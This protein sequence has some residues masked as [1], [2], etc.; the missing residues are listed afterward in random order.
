[1]GKHTLNQNLSWLNKNLGFWCARKI[2]STKSE[3]KQGVY[4][5]F[6]E[7]PCGCNAAGFYQA[8]SMTEFHP[9]ENHWHLLD[10]FDN[11]LSMFVQ[12]HLVNV[13]NTVN[14]RGQHE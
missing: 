10:G 4:W 2:S 9:C 13:F 12:E 7:W 5:V 1:M 6:Y 8:V 3:V 14:S 11:D